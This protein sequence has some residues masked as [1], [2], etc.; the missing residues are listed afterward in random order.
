MSRQYEIV[1]FGNSESGA[2]NEACEALD[3]QYQMIPGRFGREQTVL[4]DGQYIKDLSYIN[5]P[6]KDIV[7]VDFSDDSVKFHKENALI[8]PEF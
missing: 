3:P 5:R 1:I 2:I 7:Y 4:K 6:L 8:I